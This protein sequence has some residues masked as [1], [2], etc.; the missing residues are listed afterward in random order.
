MKLT[1]DPIAHNSSQNQL[2]IHNNGQAQTN[3][4]NS[5][6]QVVIGHYGHAMNSEHAFRES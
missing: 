5:Q 4:A 1:E 3:L 2:H 6:L